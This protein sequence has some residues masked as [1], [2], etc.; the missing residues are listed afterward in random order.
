[1]TYRPGFFNDISS[2]VR[3]MDLDNLLLDTDSYKHSHYR[4]YKPGTQ[5]VSSYVEAR[6]ANGSIDYTVFFGLQM[7]L[8]KLQG[9]VITEDII[10]EAEPFIRAHGLDPAIDSWRRIQESHDGRLP[11]RIDALPEGS[12]AGLRTAMMRITNTDPE[13][14]WLPTFLE[15]R[16]LRSIWYP[17]TVAT[18]S[19]AT[20]REIA[21][22][23]Q[24]TDGSSEGVEFK[25]H[26]FGARGTTSFEAAGIGGC[27]HLVA[28][29]GTDTISGLVYAR[30]FYGADMAG[31]SIPASEHS[32]MTSWGGEAGEIDAMENMLRQFPDGLVACVSDSYDLFRALN[33]YWGDKLKDQVLSRENGFLVVRPDSGNPCEILPSTIE[34]L[35]EKFGFTETATGYRLLNDKV[36]VI[37]GDGVTPQSII[38]IMQAL[39]NHKLAIGNVAFGMGAGLLQ[40]IDRDTFGFAMK[41]SAVCIEDEWHDVFKAPATSV[42]GLKASRPGRLAVVKEQP[43]VYETVRQEELAD[44]DDQ[45]ETVFLDGEVTKVHL[46]EDVRARAAQE[47]DE[48]MAA[49]AQGRWP[50]IR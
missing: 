15:T 40:K 43:G 26:D 7:E 18:N 14:Y 38:D 45:L 9:V 32:T 25:L 29:Q 16:L 22:R 21:R 49:K 10:A 41:A 35:G 13:F 17:S 42:A 8:A 47:Y 4:Q 33:E 31:Y 12:V 44:R 6:K 3:A 27:A 1:M 11:V 50:G 30:N 24:I 39:M 23:M 2:R 20:T 37:Q 36:R 46:F 48:M 5:Y 34:A 19:L 28:S